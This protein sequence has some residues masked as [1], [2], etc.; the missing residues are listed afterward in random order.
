MKHLRND[1]GDMSFFSC[2]IML[3]LIMLTSFLL[4]FFSV[5]I[6]SINI[7]NGIKMELNNLS[8]NIYSD[9][10]HSQ[11]ETN[12]EE[13]IRTLYS[14]SAYT[15]Q[16]EQMVEDGLAEKISLETKDYR[17]KNI[18][19]E[20]SQDSDGQIQ[21]IFSFDAEFY[22]IMFGNKYSVI[23]PKIRLTGHHNTKF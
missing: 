7:R 2:F 20:F 12:M 10:Y 22:V 5:K 21:Y 9:T 11:R 23:T 17:I 14:S 6:N 4:L 13:Y 15:R 16:L 1:R 3:A 18:K 19:L 8:A